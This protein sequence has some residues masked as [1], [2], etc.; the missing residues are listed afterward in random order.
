[1]AAFLASVGEKNSGR[2]FLVNHGWL[3][4]RSIRGVGHDTLHQLSFEAG[5]GK[6]AGN[7]RRF[8]NCGFYW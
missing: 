5:L 7:P 6:I 3:A 2:A 4:R 8:H 1:L